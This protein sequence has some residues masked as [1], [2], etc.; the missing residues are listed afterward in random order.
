MN[1]EALS[2]PPPPES[3]DSHGSGIGSAATGVPR[4]SSLIRDSTPLGPCSR[5]IPRAIRNST[6]LG[7]YSR[8][9]PGGPREGGVF[10]PLPL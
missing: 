6:T 8:T 7:P 1:P 3:A 10:A 2:S 4:G 5:T 9:M